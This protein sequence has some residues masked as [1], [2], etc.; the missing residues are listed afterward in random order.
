MKNKILI[1]TLL[2][3]TALSNAQTPATTPGTTTPKD[4]NEE[5][6]FRLGLRASPTFGWIKS[7]KNKIVTGNGVSLGFNWGLIADIKFADNYFFSTG[8]DVV[9]APIKMMHVSDLIDNKDTNT[10]VEFNYRTRYI[11]I[12]ITL[13]LKTKEVNYMRYYG[14]FGIEPQFNILKNLQ[15]SKGDYAGQDKAAPKDVVF[16]NYD[17]NINF[18]RL[19]VVVGGG[20]EYSLG[21]KTALLGGI[22]FNGGLTDISS[23]KDL[24]IVN[25]YIA[26]NL[27]VLF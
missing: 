15:V 1:L 24:K 14:Q 2:F 25:N 16:K 12:P 6:K 8:L 3:F 22:T 27:G 21:G 23:E 10:N 13:K 20:V 11:G 9:H 17:A 7:D 5:S 18:L 26:I 4:N 19:G